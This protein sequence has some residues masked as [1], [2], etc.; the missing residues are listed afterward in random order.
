MEPNY[1]NYLYNIFPEILYVVNRNAN[2]SWRLKEKMSF[3]N[4][5]LIYDGEAEFICNDKKFYGSKG[6]L[7]F[8]RP[9]DLRMAHTFSHNPIKCFAVDFLYCCPVF[10]NNEWNFQHPE[11]PFEYIQKIDDNYLFSRLIDLFSLLTRLSISDKNMI[12]IKE[13]SVF[14]EIL[15]LLVQYKETKEYSYSIIKKVDKVISYMAENY[16]QNITL[17]MLSDYINVSPSYLVNIFKKV[18]GRSTIDYLINIRINKAKSLLRAGFTV[19]ET[20]K[21]VGFNDIFYFSKA[22]KKYEGISPSQYIDMY[23]SNV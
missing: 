23:Y 4:M 10:L 17:K 9:G 2:T 21:L 3:Y 11:L 6:D 8:Y 19:S 16:S 1:N 15:T 14:S 13:R 22:F 7:V 5:M 20:S 12:T 18:T